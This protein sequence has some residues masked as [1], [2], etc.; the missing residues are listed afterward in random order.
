LQVVV[1]VLEVGLVLLAVLV[2]VV[3]AFNLVE[4]VLQGVES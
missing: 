2:V 4:E 1:E 3:Q